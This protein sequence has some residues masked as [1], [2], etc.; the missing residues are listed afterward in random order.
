ME[1]LRYYR[2]KIYPSCDMDLQIRAVWFN[3]LIAGRQIYIDVKIDGSSLILP[4]ND[5]VCKQEVNI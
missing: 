4:S 2:Q 1:V 5:L 3:I